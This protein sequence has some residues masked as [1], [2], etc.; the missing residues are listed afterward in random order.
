MR[1]E[2]A[3][4]WENNDN[5]RGLGFKE[6]DP[7]QVVWRM[8]HQMLCLQKA[9][10]TECLEKLG[11]GSGGEGSWALSVTKGSVSKELR[12]WEDSADEQ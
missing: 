5:I 11:P 8:R 3:E 12:Q 10:A 6:A 2:E 9:P 7:C 1:N 4:S